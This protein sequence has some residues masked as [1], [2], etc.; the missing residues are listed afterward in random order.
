MTI[1]DFFYDK[2]SS[3]TTYLPRMTTLSAT[4]ALYI[5]LGEGGRWEKSSID[6]G[7]L[8]FG[9]PEIPHE[10][11]LKR[12]WVEA[13]RIES[14][15]VPNAGA[16]TR[17]INQVKEFYLADDSVI[18]ITFHVGKLWWCKAERDVLVEHGNEKIRKVVGKWSD[19]SLSGK[20]LWKRDISGR[21]L[22]VEKFRGTICSIAEFQ[23]LLH[24]ING[25]NEPH[26]HAAQSAF[27]ALQTA[28]IP[29]IQDLHEFD[30]EIFVDLIFRQSGWQRVGVNGGTEKDIDLDLLSPAT[31]DRIAVQ[32]KSTADEKV[33]SG[34]KASLTELGGYSKFYFVCHSPSP[35]LKKLTSTERDLGM[36][37]WDAAELASQAV[38]GGL[39]GWLLDKAS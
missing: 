32:V 33:W 21:L 37:F 2:I 16:V 17:H 38:R 12:D 1:Y 39:T 18:W 11:C 14:E 6:L 10:V 26:V 35:S 15:L 24:K 30:F 36:V 9:Y 4:R 19:K 25:T 13:A 20:T 8:R 23:Y 7:E 27:Q 22:K 29:I 31:G 3:Q 28:L 5:K 34:Y